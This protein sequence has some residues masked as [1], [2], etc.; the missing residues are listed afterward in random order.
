MSIATLKK[1]TN[2]QY[3]NMSVG[4][5]G[6]SINGTHRNQGYVGQ[7][8]LSRSLPKTPMKGNV[9]CGNGGCCGTYLIKPIV[10]S[11]V[12]TTE[13]SNV[14]KSS[15][16]NTLGMINTHYRWIRRPAPYT[17]VKPDNNI[18]LNNSQGQWIE[19]VRKQTIL[20]AD[21]CTLNSIPSN[22]T[23]GCS[24][25]ENYQRP[26]KRQLCPQLENDKPLYNK[27]LSQSDYLDQLDDQCT[28]NEVFY[29]P[30][31]TKI[32]VPIVN[33]VS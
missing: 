33:T 4:L 24:V 20:E 17:S 2:T 16:I 19:Y 9:I 18:S 25:L 31:S 14:V 22:N 8:S 26:K 7:T 21:Q 30:S 3:N 27:Y 29:V 28:Q 1:K 32:G 11:A 10:Q 5:H 15:V 13:N 23:S 6:F 12:T